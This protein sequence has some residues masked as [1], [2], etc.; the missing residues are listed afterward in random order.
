MIEAR[1]RKERLLKGA[2]NKFALNH[3]VISSTVTTAAAGAGA[4]GATGAGAAANNGLNHCRNTKSSLKSFLSINKNRSSHHHNHSSNSSIG[5]SSIGDE[6]I[7]GNDNQILNDNN[8]V[9]VTINNPI[10]SHQM[11]ATA[12]TNS[13]TMS[14]LS[15]ECQQRDKNQLEKQQQQ[16]HFDSSNEEQNR[17]LQRTESKKTIS[18]PI[19]V[20]Q[21]ETASRNNSQMNIFKYC[22]HCSECLQNTTIV[23]KFTQSQTTITATP[24]T[25]ATANDPQQQKLKI[26]FQSGAEKISIQPES[27]QQQQQTPAQQQ[28]LTNQHHQTFNQPKQPGQTSTAITTSSGNSDRTTR[29]LIAVLI[30][31]LICEF[32]SGILA[33]LSGIL[34]KLFFKNVYN[35]F[36]DLMD[37]LALINSAVNFVL[38]CLMSQQFRKT[39]SHLFCIRWTEEISSGQTI[40]H[41]K[42]S[43]V[44]GHGESITLKTVTKRH[45][46]S[47]ITSQH[48]PTLKVQEGAI[49][50]QV[51]AQGAN[52][53][54]ANTVLVTKV[55]DNVHSISSSSTMLDPCSSTSHSNGTNRNSLSSI[56]KPNNVNVL[57]NI[58]IECNRLQQTNGDT[59]MGPIPASANTSL[60]KTSYISSCV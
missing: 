25:S 31:F 52:D 37:M 53:H 56:I 44:M 28:Q 47:I 1:K 46:P 34:G 42:Y 12:A 8:H 48:G 49:E 50:T 45:D 9:Q 15:D 26:K 14:A 22:L 57:E 10:E 24:S 19:T 3:N 60:T 36:G 18:T 11:D 43:T 16:K 20:Q 35:N 54:T 55:A 4:G 21:Y 32:P 23:R 2:N 33:L 39:F 29:M 6:N 51:I 7:I 27:L 17:Q 58:V 38:Y 30:M 41:K 59:T 13:T 5:D 40:Q